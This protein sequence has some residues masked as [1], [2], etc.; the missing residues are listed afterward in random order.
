MDCKAEM[1][2]SSITRRISHRS[3]ALFLSHLCYCLLVKSFVNARPKGLAIWRALH[4]LPGIV[5]SRA[6]QS[7]SICHRLYYLRTHKLWLYILSSVSHNWEWFISHF[8]EI[9]SLFIS[10]NQIKSYFTNA[11]STVVKKRSEWFDF[12][13]SAN[14]NFIAFFMFANYI[15]TVGFTVYMICWSCGLAVSTH[16]S[17]THLAMNEGN[18]TYQLCAPPKPSA[19]MFFFLV[20]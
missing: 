11:T 9:W 12:P 10:K 17:C 19:Q 14:F 13:P 4:Q 20:F 1:E 5:L 8:C 7:F 15:F 18:I 2:S 16:A 6:D 3:L